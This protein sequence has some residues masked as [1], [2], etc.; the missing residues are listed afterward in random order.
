[1]SRASA[2]PS[3]IGCFA[4]AAST[5]IGTPMIQ[6]DQGERTVSTAS[7]SDGKPFVSDESDPNGSPLDAVVGLC[8]RLGPCRT[9]AAFGRGRMGPRT[10]KRLLSRAWSL[11]S[12]ITSHNRTS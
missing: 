11:H 4:S 5:R 10:D 2:P 8:A 7:K 9:S 3:D 12:V 1:L 6:M